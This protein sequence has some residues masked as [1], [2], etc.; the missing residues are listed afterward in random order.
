MFDVWLDPL[1]FGARAVVSP[2]SHDRIPVNGCGLIFPLKAGRACLFVRLG[3]AAPPRRPGPKPNPIARRHYQI[4]QNFPI[5]R[6]FLTNRAGNVR[7][8]V[9]ATQPPAPGHQLSSAPRTQ[10][11][12]PCY[13]NAFKITIIK[14]ILSETLQPIQ[15]ATLNAIRTQGSPSRIG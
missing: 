8:L 12:K 1:G 5:T 4:L 13:I 11:L 3:A 10:T 2:F 6:D 15:R 7:P 14:T 9:A